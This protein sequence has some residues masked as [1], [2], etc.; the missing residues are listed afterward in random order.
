MTQY[1]V[2]IDLLS[3]S[4][5]LGNIEISKITGFP[6]P[7]VRRITGILTL[8]KIL[9]RVDE[10][11]YTI[12]PEAIIFRHYISASFY[13]SGS[14]DEA[15]AHSYKSDEI[16]IFQKLK[17]KLILKADDTCGSIPMVEKGVRAITKTDFNYSINSIP[18]E[19]RDFMAIYPNIITSFD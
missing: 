10:G 19:D 4:Q 1:D 5:P 15:W 7:S 13:C 9:E 11:I 6:E 18:Y 16:D 12:S 3:K 8:K 2:V 14:L 17:T